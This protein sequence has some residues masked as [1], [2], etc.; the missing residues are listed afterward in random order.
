MAVNTQRTRR[1]LPPLFFVIVPRRKLT[2]VASLTFPIPRL[3]EGVFLT[4]ICLLHGMPNF[5]DAPVFYLN[6]SLAKVFA[7]AANFLIALC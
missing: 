3:S 2:F 7:A 4:M 5:S 6:M 1:I